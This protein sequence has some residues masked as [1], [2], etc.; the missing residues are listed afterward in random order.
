MNNE[1]ECR[2]LFE[3]K[4]NPWKNIKLYF[5]GKEMKGIVPFIFEPKVTY[6]KGDV[7]SY[8]GKMIEIIESMTK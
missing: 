7:L 2:Y 1:F 6:T 8:E 3:E 4:P 5:D